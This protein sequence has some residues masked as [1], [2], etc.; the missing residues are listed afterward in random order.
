VGY[1]RAE[2]PKLAHLPDVE[3]EALAASGAA[4]NSLMYTESQLLQ[5]RIDS[6]GKATVYSPEVP[7]EARRTSDDIARTIAGVPSTTKVQ[8]STRLRLVNIAAACGTT[9]VGQLMRAVVHVETASHALVWAREYTISAGA[10]ASGGRCTALVLESVH[11]PR[12]RLRFN[13]AMVKGAIALASVDHAGMLLPTTPVPEVV[14]RSWRQ[15]PFA[16]PLCSA[17][18]SSWAFLVPSFISLRPSIATQPF[19][20]FVVPRR[21]QGWA[22][23]KERCTLVPLHASGLFANVPSPKTALQLF[24]QYME[25]RNYVAAANMLHQCKGIN[26]E[27]NAVRSWCLALA[28]STGEDNKGLQCARTRF[29][30]HTPGG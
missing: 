12:L 21:E 18:K 14:A 9:P 30:C 25:R 16:L 2:H 22:S 19:S 10:A 13:V 28:H 26:F 4:T 1:P 23:W 29:A 15:L 24:A 17:D 7:V 3:R 5:V 8:P 6:E 27:D 11:L 20:T